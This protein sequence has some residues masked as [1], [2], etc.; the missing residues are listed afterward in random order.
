MIRIADVHVVGLRVPFRRPVVSATHAWPERR[1]ALVRLHADGGIGGLG[2][3]ALTT[4]GGLDGPGASGDRLAQRLGTELVG[5]DVADDDALGDALGRI[6]AWPE[7]GRAVRSAVETAAADV[8]ARDA[9]LSLAATMTADPRTQVAVNALVG[10]A[11]PA[12]AVAEALAHVEAGYAVLK[13]KG[14]GEPV[15]QLIERIAAVRA[16]VGPHIA[17]RVDVNGSL[18]PAAAPAVLEA[19][20]RFDLEYVEQPLAAGT[21]VDA[22]AALR[23]VS[24]V[25]IAADEDVGDPAAARAL[26]EAGAADVLVVKPARVG[27]ARSARRIIEL[28]ASSDVPAVLSTLFET[29]TGIATALHLAAAMP[30]PDRAHGLATADVL[31]SDLLERPLSVARGRMAV[32]TGPGLG[33]EIDA[34]AVRRYA[35]A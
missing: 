29:G 5:L 27:G 17:L 19:L 31:V 23:R 12:Q 13:L 8:R 18:D 20:A 24:A 15:E 10:I 7:I 25:A 22:A 33:I 35:D 16:A 1:L 2:E 32:P 11:A 14:G 21:G 6:D 4:P 3:V 9:G 30:A 28:A 26:I 34:A